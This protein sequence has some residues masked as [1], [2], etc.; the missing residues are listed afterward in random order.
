MGNRRLLVFWDVKAM[1]L[2]CC[3]SDGD[4]FGLTGFLT[5]FSPTAGGFALG[6][7]LLFSMPLAWRAVADA[8]AE[9]TTPV[10]AAG[11]SRPL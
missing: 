7:L 6:F 2:P 11:D 5:V 10:I 1:G 3:A 8:V 4:V 9:G